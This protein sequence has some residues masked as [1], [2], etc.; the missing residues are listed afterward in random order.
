MLRRVDY[1]SLWLHSKL[2]LKG[3]H[4]D[5]GVLSGALDFCPSYM[6]VEF[7][8]VVGRND[9]GDITGA[10][11]L[12]GKGQEMCE[13]SLCNNSLGKWSDQ[14]EIIQITCKCLPWKCGAFN[15]GI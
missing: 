10:R 12:A 9:K 5:A 4:T 1:I 2:L 14:P 11:T 7:C 8:E 3:L 13:N 6:W 15:Q